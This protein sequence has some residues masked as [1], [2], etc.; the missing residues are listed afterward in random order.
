[1]RL[2][3]DH[4]PGR[5]ALAV[6]ALLMVAWAASEC[7]RDA[8]PLDATTVAARA[9][10][11]SS[12]R[13]VSHELPP[14]FGDAR[15]VPTRIAGR[16]FGGAYPVTVRLSIN[17][18]DPGLWAGREIV[19]AVDGTFD[20]G[21]LRPGPYLL[22]AFGQ[23]V[24]SRATRLDTT[25]ERGDQAE[26][27]A[28]ACKWRSHTLWRQPPGDADPMATVPAAGV[29]VEIAGRVMGTADGAGSFTVCRDRHAEEQFRLA[30][31]EAAD[32]LTMRTDIADR[33]FLVAARTL[34]GIVREANGAPAGGIGVQPYWKSKPAQS[35][36]TPSRDVVTTDAAGRFTH[37][38]S[39][40]TCGFRVFRGGMVQDVVVASD[41]PGPVTVPLPP[42]GRE[43]RG[44]FDR[45]RVLPAN[46]PRGAWIRGRIVQRGALVA[47][48]HVRLKAP[49]SHSFGDGHTST[50]HDGS[51]ALFVSRE[52]DR[53][54]AARLLAYATPADAPR[55][56]LISPS[57][58]A[59]APVTS[60]A[61]SASR[62]SGLCT[63]APAM[64]CTVVDLA[65]RQPISGVAVEIGDGVMVHGVVVDQRGR[66]MAGVQIRSPT[67]R[68][69]QDTAADGSFA[70]RLPGQGRY[71]LYAYDED[72][73][74]LVPPPGRIPPAIDL[75]HP[76][77]ERHG[78]RVVVQ[79]GEARSF[80][81]E[82]ISEEMCLVDL[83]VVL[84]DD[85]VVVR[86]G[87]EAEAAGMQ[88]GDR[89]IS[90]DASPN[91]S[92]PPPGVNQTLE[93]AFIVPF[94]GELR[95][96]VQRRGKTLSFHARA[97]SMR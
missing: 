69:S 43:V 71:R 85:N 84:D 46:D 62:L 52:L 96:T 60:L 55:A 92:P 86:I 59:S 57:Q 9:D 67:R 74:A 13:V 49:G 75:F 27:F 25:Y 5:A 90:T 82:F 51:F 76:D 94:S 42:A 3:G 37:S 54:H 64:G 41:P 18:P 1:M 26:V 95:W 66:P 23:G 80:M 45:T 29:A 72:G 20:F 17:A 87:D 97:P 63:L 48:G 91:G 4:G 33:R 10:F 65:P 47:D 38:G 50:R 21:E 83:G 35:G 70:I 6:L 61:G 78:V 39:H 44:V 89:V 56:P 58:A 34:S 22:L 24:I 12:G 16:I 53:R 77:G 79:R 28:Y 11:V 40:P 88:L 31:H 93:S 15:R 19:A 73:D 30:G 8:R 7:A 68:A 2:I 14:W 36:C 32:W 81:N